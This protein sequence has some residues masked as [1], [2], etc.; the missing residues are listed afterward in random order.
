[1]WN[2]FENLFSFLGCLIL[3]RDRKPLFSVWLLEFRQPNVQLI[4]ITADLGICVAEASNYQTEYQAGQSGQNLNRINMSAVTMAGYPSKNSFPQEP[5]PPPPICGEAK[6]APEKTFFSQKLPQMAVNLSMFSE[7]SSSSPN[8]PTE[9]LLQE[10]VSFPK[11]WRLAGELSE[12]FR[13]SRGD[14]NP[15]LWRLQVYTWLECDSMNHYTHCQVPRLPGLSIV[16][17]L[18]ICTQAHSNTV[19]HLQ[20]HQQYINTLH[21]LGQEFQTYPD[22]E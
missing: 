11:M 13:H 22:L 9:I 12:M 18:S 10:P 7:K 17:S 1:M 19:Q 16:T 15:H 2:V 21:S 5:P 6:I 14:I 3:V 8:F 4:K 20:P